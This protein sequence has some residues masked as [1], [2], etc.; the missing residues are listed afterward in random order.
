LEECGD[1]KIY[2]SYCEIVFVKQGSIYFIKAHLLLPKEDTES[3]FSSNLPVAQEKSIFTYL[4]TGGG[5][6]ADT[7]PVSF[8][9]RPKIG[10]R[11]V[12]HVS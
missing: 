3:K 6:G 7:K 8:V 10:V 4:T 11:F 5:G 2:V 9:H 1:G 12:C